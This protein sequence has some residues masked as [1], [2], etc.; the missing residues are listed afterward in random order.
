M[1][2]EIVIACGGDGLQN[3]IAQQAVAT[4]GIMAVLPLGRGNDF[5]SSLKI[6]CVEDTVLALNNNFIHEARY[7]VAEFAN[8]SKIALTSTG[9]GLLSEAAF[10]ATKIPLLKGRILYSI[11]SL[12]CF[13]NLKCHEYKQEIDGVK[14]QS[15]SLIIA[16]AASEY[17]GGG[18]FIAPFAKKEPNLL[19]VLSAGAV[20]RRTAIT[21]LNKAIHGMHLAHPNVDNGYFSECKIDSEATNFWSKLVYGDGEFLGELPVKFS[22]GKKP[23]R[24]LV[25]REI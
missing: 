1:A 17:T 21:L 25:P 6:N 14:T 9:V 23:L 15:R 10:R 24:V 11:A 12:I 3:L 4:G 8:H 7:V 13:I 19:N 20:N 18:I 5:A 16:A 2:G 22:L